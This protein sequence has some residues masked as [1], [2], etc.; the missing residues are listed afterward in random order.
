M[1]LKSLKIG[2]VV[3]ESKNVKA[4]K[5][6][7][8]KFENYTFSAL[9]KLGHGTLTASSELQKPSIYL[10]VKNLPPQTV[11]DA[12]KILISAYENGEKKQIE[13]NLPVWNEKD[14]KNRY[15]R[16]ER[17]Q[18]TVFLTID[19][20]DIY[21]YINSQEIAEYCRAIKRRFTATECAYITE[22]SFRLTIEEKMKMFQHIIDTMPDEPAGQY[23][24]SA[25]G[26]RIILHSFLKNYIRLLGHGVTAFF[27]FD[28][29]HVYDCKI[30]FSNHEGTGHFGL[31]RS[32]ES[33]LKDKLWD[34]YEE[35]E[36]QGII[37][38]KINVDTQKKETCYLNCRKEPVF[39][40]MTDCASPVFR[41]VGVWFACP[42]PFKKGDIV[43]VKGGP[44]RADSSPFVFESACYEGQTEQYYR[45]RCAWGDE[46]DM[47]VYG[48]CL[49]DGEEIYFDH[50]ED[51]DLSLERCEEESEYWKLKCL[52]D[53]VR[54][55]DLKKLVN[56]FIVKKNTNLKILP[57]DKSMPF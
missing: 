24:P 9:S 55:N 26:E 40:D 38:D 49:D 39:M 42:M 46:T 5:I 12:Q 32:A 31:W 7:G 28:M 11:S 54:E 2:Y 30:L 20:F 13:L 43:Y 44:C 1:E 33:F 18:N 8:K 21:A 17:K 51:E 25:A 19:P 29:N 4:F 27:R 10:A 57:Y 52:S 22:H 53:C 50:I 15:E 6:N 45:N 23:D 16:I 41:D 36:I 3:A 14:E 35:N 56:N 48:Y 34:E 47:V 37:I